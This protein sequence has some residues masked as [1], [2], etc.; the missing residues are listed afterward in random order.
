VGHSSGRYSIFLYA[1]NLKCGME[2]L[3]NII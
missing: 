3:N 1:R 2:V